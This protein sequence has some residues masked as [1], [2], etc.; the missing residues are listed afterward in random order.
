MGLAAGQAR[1]LGLTARK[2]NVEYQGQQI[3]QARTALSNEVLGLYRKY[4][5][6]EVPTPPSKTDYTK[7][8]Y[9]IESAYEDYQ[10]SSFNKIS[11]GE[12]E[13]YYNVVLECP[14]DIP[15]AYS[16]T[17]KDSVVTGQ[18]KELEN[19]KGEYTYLEFQLGTSEFIYDANDPDGSNL[20]KIEVNT[21]DEAKEYAGLNTIIQKNGYDLTKNNVFYRFIKDG[22]TYYTPESD[23]PNF[24]EDVTDVDSKGR[25]VYYG[26]Y[27]F[28]YQGTKKETKKVDAIAALQKDKSGRLSSIDVIKCDGD[29]DLAG[30]SYSINVET[31]EDE[32][33]YQDAMN[34]YNYKKDKYER[35]VELINKKTEIIQKED[36]SLEL[37]LNQL[38]TE[39]NALKTEME[40]LEKVIEDTIKNIFKTYSS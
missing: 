3:N 25:Y 23:L 38:D 7:T 32:K 35:Q 24:G 4:N 39:Q 12:Y 11:S 14:Q 1:F 9:T 13:G 21:L 18:K 20:T 36:R 6:L 16:K 33:A 27:R 28:D 30:N 19:G 17:F 22:I 29:P 37:Q 10:I 5:A 34:K 31:E 15:K 2:S 8:I 26:D 40:S